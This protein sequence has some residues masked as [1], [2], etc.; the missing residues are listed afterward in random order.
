M[1]TVENYTIEMRESKLIVL[2]FKFAHNF[3]VLYDEQGR[4]VSELHG[5]AT[6]RKTH[7]AKPVKWLSSQIRAWGST[8][9]KNK[10]RLSPITAASQAYTA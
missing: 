1:P 3:W 4:I 10:C 9:Y 6:N 5:L 7:R 2:F 8:H